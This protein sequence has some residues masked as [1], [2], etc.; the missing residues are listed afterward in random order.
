MVLVKLAF[1]ERGIRRTRVRPNAAGNYITARIY[2]MVWWL[3]FPRTDKHYIQWDAYSPPYTLPVGYIFTPPPEP[4]WQ[5]LGA[6][7]SPN[8]APTISGVPEPYA[9]VPAP[10]APTLP[11]FTSIPIPPPPLLPPP[12]LPGLPTGPVTPTYPLAAPDFFADTLLTG[13]VPTR[14]ADRPTPIRAVL[15]LAHPTNT[16][17]VYFRSTRQQSG[18]GA[19]PPGMGVILEIDDASKVMVWS[20]TGGQALTYAY[21]LQPRATIPG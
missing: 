4:P 3:A 10:S 8:T 7:T 16:E 19:L 1:R 9:P 17:V 6:V 18:Q 21:E 13:T 5:L 2:N 20:S 15:L 12:L 14:L 11:S